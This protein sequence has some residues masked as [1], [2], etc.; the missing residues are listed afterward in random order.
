MWVVPR[1]ELTEDQI[2]AVNLST[3]KHRIIVG[4]PG[5][6][7]TLALAHRARRLLDDGR[8]PEQI[9]LLVYTRTLARYLRTGLQELGIP[10]QVVKT[11]DAWC[12]EVYRDEVSDRPPRRPGSKS[13]DFEAVRAAVLKAREAKGSYPRL[14][15]VLVDE[16]QDLDAVAIRLLAATASHVTLAMDQRQQLYSEKVDVATA[17]EILGVRRPQGN[18]L[19]AYRCTPLIVDVASVFLPDDEAER[20]R[21]SNLLPLAEREVP[22]LEESVSDEAE[23]DVLA[24]RLGERALLG[25]RSA[26]LVP[27]RDAVRRVA[28]GL[29]KRGVNVVDMDEA[30]FDDIRPVVITYHSAKGLTVE[31]VLLPQLT[32]SAFPARDDVTR[33]RNQLFVGIS[34]ATHWVWLGRRTGQDLPDIP[35]FDQFPALER[36]GSL[37]VVRTGAEGQT[38]PPVTTAPRAAATS[39]PAVA[40]STD[41]RDLL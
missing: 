25:Q 31:S 14:D 17:A 19:T 9:R 36:R 37:T 22:M 38:S 7:K 15:V 1:T 12:L 34:R 6:G 3:D 41:I 39:A 11:F 4:G 5:S 10:E 40:A 35:G 24:K 20:F 30:E 18:L 28:T 23:L 26:V 33:V 8:P 29:R 13:P 2:E 27:Y 16:A 32:A 21:A